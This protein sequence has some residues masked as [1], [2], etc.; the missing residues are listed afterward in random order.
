MRLF[1]GIP[2]PEKEKKIIMNGIK[3]YLDI[4]GLKWVAESNLHIT[5]KFLGEVNEEKLKRVRERLKNM[6][7]HESFNVISSSIGAF[8]SPSS[9]RVIWLGVKEGYEEISELNENIEEEMKKIGFKREKRFHPHITLCRVK[10]YNRD[11]DRIFKE[12]INIKFKV[13]IF[14]LY[15]SVLYKD[16][17]EY[18]VIE[19][20]RL[21]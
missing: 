4:P 2:I 16:G 14:N 8:P 17:P 10:K 6:E 11:I 13:S 12:S 3:K 7:S 21:K 20:Y 15:R 9:P 19:S 5:L 1:V 18:S